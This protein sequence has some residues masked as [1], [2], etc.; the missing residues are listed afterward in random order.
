MIHYCYRKSYVTW[1][2]L[3][4][5]TYL[6]TLTLDI[7]AAILVTDNVCMKRNFIFRLQSYTALFTRDILAYN[8]ALKDIQ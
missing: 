6:S 7:Q 2:K 8:I 4:F 3:I 1:D 5:K